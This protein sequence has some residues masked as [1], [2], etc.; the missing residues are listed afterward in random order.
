MPASDVSAWAKASTKPTYSLS[1]ITGADDIKAIEA[2]ES[3]TGLLRKTATN[4]WTLDTTTY[5]T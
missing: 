4:K 2:L 1:E 3:A 5:L